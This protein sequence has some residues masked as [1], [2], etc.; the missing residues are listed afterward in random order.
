[1]SAPAIRTGAS[2]GKLLD[3]AD[4]ALYRL[5]A[6]PPPASQLLAA[7]PAFS[8]AAV[9]LLVASEGRRHADLAAETRAAASDSLTAT[10]L[11]LRATLAAAA[12]IASCDIPD[13]ALTRVADLIGAAADLVQTAHDRPASRHSDVARSDDARTVGTIRTA[14]IVHSTVDITVRAVGRLHLQPGAR[15][16][17]GTR[18][19]SRA[20]VLFPVRRSATDVL[21]TAMGREPSA[22]AGRGPLYDLRVPT[23]ELL[24]PTD[25]LGRL[26]ISVAAWRDASLRAAERPAVSS[27]ELLRATVEARGIVAINAAV[28]DAAVA[29]GMMSPEHGQRT[30]GQLQ[31][32]GAAWSA[33]TDAWTRFATGVRP[34]QDFL[35]A[36]LTLQGSMRDLTRNSSGDWVSPAV[37]A[38]R[39]DI[40]DA[41]P[42]MRAALGHVVD[43]GHAHG[44]AVTRLA[45]E[46]GGLYAPA[47][48]LEVTTERLQAHIR[49]RYV[50]VTPSEA[51]VVVATYDAAAARTAVAG[52]HSHARPPKPTQWS[53]HEPPARKVQARP[54]Q[55]STSL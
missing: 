21:D 30:L 38:T 3:Q 19:S 39:L 8:R 11:R 54:P 44:A 29:A 23:L 4:E 18:I 53:A 33:V 20:A 6:T 41:T 17:T 10:S 7:W 16:R 50:P 47:R 32:A 12:T 9:W 31:R 26:Q 55:G 13:P 2:V 35:D 49:G 5:A 15:P 27:I 37:L 42:V 22:R 51:S 36:S 1:M 28:T 48:Q 14:E 52:L 25:P 43:M 34:S 40:A 24:D 46:T 45:T